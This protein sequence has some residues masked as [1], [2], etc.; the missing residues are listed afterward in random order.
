MNVIRVGYEERTNYIV[1]DIYRNIELV[2]RRMA[3]F[4]SL[5]VKYGANID[6][7]HVI[8]FSIGGAIV[9][10]VGEFLVTRYNLLVGQ[11]TGKLQMR[12]T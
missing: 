6:D 7:I 2:G 3:V 8:G 5:L 11:I 1:V 9:A 12:E 4:I 10:F